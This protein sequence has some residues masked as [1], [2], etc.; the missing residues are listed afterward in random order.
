MKEFV[1]DLQR[2]EDIYNDENDTI[3]NG[4]AGKDYIYNSYGTSLSSAQRQI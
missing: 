4:G 1:F 2:F 3:I